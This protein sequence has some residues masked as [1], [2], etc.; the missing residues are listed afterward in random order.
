MDGTGI[1]RQSGTFTSPVS[2]QPLDWKIVGP[3]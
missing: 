2:L 1:N 3:R